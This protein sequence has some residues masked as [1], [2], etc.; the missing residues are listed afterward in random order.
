MD[1]QGI[2]A[3]K[4]KVSGDHYKF[5]WKSRGSTS[6]KSIS[7]IKT[8]QFFSG[9]VHFTSISSKSIPSSSLYFIKGKLFCERLFVLIAHTAHEGMTF[10]T[11]FPIDKLFIP[12]HTY[13]HNYLYQGLMHHLSNCLMLTATFLIIYFFIRRRVSFKFRSAQNN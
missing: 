8:V 1:F 2:N 6:K 13:R 7:Y 12:K 5:D 10:R 3:K 11:P 4:W 9:K